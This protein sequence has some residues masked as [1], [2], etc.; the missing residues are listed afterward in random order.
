MKAL[1]ICAAAGALLAGALPASAEVVVREGGV[2]VRT[3]NHHRAGYHHVYHRSYASCRVIKVKTRRANGTV[4]IR[5][6]RVC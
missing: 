6:R 2:V 4:V 1:M 5:T 3:D